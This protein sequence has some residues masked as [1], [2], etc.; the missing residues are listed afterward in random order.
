MRWISIPFLLLLS[1]SL[2]AAGPEPY[3]KSAQMPFYPRLARLARISGTI[4]LDFTVDGQ[5]N[6]SGVEASAANEV[7]RRSAIENVQNWKFAWSQPCDC[8]SQGEAIFVY[9][10][11]G[12][13]ESPERPNVT[14][15]WFG[16]TKVIHV[17]IEG[18]VIE[19]SD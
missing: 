12:K 19:H 14:V 7:L 18:D 6:T 3:L 11:S 8:R 9:K 4:H 16:K 1:V 15:R 10:L 2:F 17:E 5:G 13:G